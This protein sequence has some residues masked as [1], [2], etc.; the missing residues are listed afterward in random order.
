MCRL[1]P[2]LI[3]LVIPAYRESARLP[4]LLEDLVREALA[5]PAPATEL[6]VVDDGSGPVEVER[7][8]AAAA[9]SAARLERAAVPHRL[10]FLAVPENRGKGA[11]IRRGWANADPGASWLGFLDADGAVSAR[12][13]W[14]L[15]RMLER[16]EDFDVLAATRVLMAG[17]SIERSAFRHLQGRLFATLA[18]GFFHLKFYDTQCGFKLFRAEALRQLLSS[19]REERWLLDIEVLALLRERGARFREEPID[20]S[21]PGGSKVVPGLDAL[22]MALGL[23]KM[24]R[25]IGSPPWRG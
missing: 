16:A 6:L 12:E 4:S 5:A 14:R 9:A 13:T 2:P 22:R 18:E 3:A 15:L 19:L 23:W 20:W 25:R 17:R 8:Q 7:E 1:P 11:A 24:R 10:R 21:D